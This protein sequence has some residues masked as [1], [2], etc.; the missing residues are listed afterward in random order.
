MVNFPPYFIRKVYIFCHID[1]HYSSIKQWLRDKT[2][3]IFSIYH[4]AQR[5][6]HCIEKFVYQQISKNSE[7]I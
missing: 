4:E 3:E 7:M 2:I 5:F 1:F 6:D